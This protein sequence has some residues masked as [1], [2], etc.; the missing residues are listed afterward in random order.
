[1]KMDR[2]D[3]M[4]LGKKLQHHVLFCYLYRPKRLDF[5][6]TKL[7]K[8]EDIRAYHKY[9]TYL[10]KIHFH[11]IFNEKNVRKQLSDFVKIFVD[12]SSRR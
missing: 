6:F 1:M 4:I 7:L 5:I 9:F 8:L 10:Y 2:F 3:D 12:F 11:T